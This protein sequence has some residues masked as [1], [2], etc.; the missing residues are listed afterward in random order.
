MFWQYIYTVKIETNFL[1]AFPFFFFFFFVIPFQIQKS[2]IRRWN[3]KKTKHPKMDPIYRSILSK[4]MT[5]LS[6]L[7]NSSQLTW[8]LY[9]IQNI[10]W[11]LFFLKHNLYWKFI[12]IRISHSFAKFLLEWKYKNKLIIGFPFVLTIFYPEKKLR[13]VMGF[14]FFFNLF[15]ESFSSP[16]IRYYLLKLQKD[17]TYKMH[18]IML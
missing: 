3:I 1:I 12:N 6:K 13:I 10:M 11:F 17:K 14:P 8:F 2:D 7:V 18:S 16:K 5:I 9:H 15:C 4:V